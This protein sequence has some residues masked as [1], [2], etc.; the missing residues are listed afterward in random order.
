MRKTWLILC[1]CFSLLGSA[2]SASTTNEN[3]AGSGGEVQQDENTSAE[4]KYW[5]FSTPPT[6]SALY[7]YCVGVANMISTIYPEYQITAAENQGAVQITRLVRDGNSMLGNSVSSTDYESYNG[8]GDFEGEANENTRILWYYAITPQQFVVSVES[9]ISKASDLQGKKFNPGGTTTSAESLTY[10]MMEAL[11]VEPDYFIAGQSDAGDAYSSRQIVGCVKAGPAGDSFVLQLDAS[12]PCTL[13]SFSDDEISKILEKIPYVVPYM[14]PA[15][16]YSGQEEDCQTVMTMMGTQ[17][18]SE[19][20]QEDGYKLISAYL[21]EEGRA[22]VDAAYPLG[23]NED[24]LELTL[25]SPIPLHAGT[26]QY[27]IEQ[28]Y[29]VPENLIP[30]E[31]ES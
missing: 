27:L 11:G 23:A 26:V 7:P 9:G 16:T 2:C 20:S 5:T 1:A 4:T 21:S 28:G 25:Q 13:L 10:A 15:G 8:V 18:T 12:V 30:P 22:I 14:I 29:E 17:T 3:S 19:M 24:I 6:S 31:Y